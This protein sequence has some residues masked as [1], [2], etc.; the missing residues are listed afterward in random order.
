MVTPVSV[1]CNV[2]LPGCCYPKGQNWQT[3]QWRLMILPPQCLSLFNNTL[4][5]LLVVIRTLCRYGPFDLA[6]LNVAARGTTLIVCNTATWFLHFDC[7]CPNYI[8]WNT[9][10]AFNILFFPYKRTVF[11]P[12]ALWSQLPFFCCI[13]PTMIKKK[14]KNLS[15]INF[16]LNFS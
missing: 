13:K 15:L 10:F 16:T 6:R 12:L 1:L 2:L 8:C 5:V 14:K 4:I 7:N 3:L 11:F 9:I